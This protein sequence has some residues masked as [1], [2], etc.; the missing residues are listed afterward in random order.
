MESPPDPVIYR[1]HPGMGEIYSLIGISASPREI[2]E[3]LT[4]FD[5]YPEWNPFIREIQG[6]LDVGS[7][8]NVFLQPPGSWGM[9][10]RPVLLSV[11]PSRELRWKGLFL[12]RGLLDGEHSFTIREHGDGTSLFIQRECFSGILLPLMERLLIQSTCQGFRA[13]NEALRSRCDRR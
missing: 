1:K 3:V 11:V 6:N 12:V 13:M 5:Q 2:W 8:L 10:I 7:R 4:R 9:R